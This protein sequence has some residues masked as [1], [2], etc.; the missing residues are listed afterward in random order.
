MLALLA[1][2]RADTPAQ[3]TE[4]LYRWIFAIKPPMPWREVVAHRK[5][6]L[7]GGLLN[8]LLEAE[9]TRRLDFDVFV[10][11]NGSPTGYK[12]EA[13]SGATVRV[14]LHTQPHDVS[15]TLHWR[16]QDGWKLDDIEYPWAERL[17]SLCKELLDD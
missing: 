7:S 14:T 2:A 13:L 4:E 16:Q 9:R 15:Q 12:V 8:A 1:P 11:V 10:P 5:D 6:L 17:R 3:R